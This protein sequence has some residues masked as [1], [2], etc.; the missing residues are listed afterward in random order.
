[1]VEAEVISAFILYM[2]SATYLFCTVSGSMFHSLVRNMYK[3]T[4]QW[5]Y[6]V[7]GYYSFLLPQSPL[8]V[9]FKK[10]HAYIF[11]WVVIKAA[12]KVLMA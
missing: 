2:D 12:F 10:Y 7:L 4:G 8:K 9:S 11:Y 6:S 1:M 5:E 3:V